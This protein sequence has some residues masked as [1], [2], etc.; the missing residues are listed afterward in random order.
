MGQVSHVHLF[1]EQTLYLNPNHLLEVSK[2][3]TS[4]LGHFIIC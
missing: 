3:A 1:A 4:P 2:A